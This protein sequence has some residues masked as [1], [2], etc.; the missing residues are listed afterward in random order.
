MPRRWKAPCMEGHGRRCTTSAALS[1]TPAA[2]TLSFKAASSHGRQK[3]MAAAAV[4]SAR[5]TR[6]WS[7]ATCTTSAASCGLRLATPILTP[8]VSAQPVRTSGSPRCPTLRAA[9]GH[10]HDHQEATVPLVARTCERLT[11]CSRLALRVSASLP[12][13][14]ASGARAN[15]VTP[16]AAGRHMEVG[17]QAELAGG[18]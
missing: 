9:G 3:A 4:K 1:C 13:R 7:T 10:A 18:V 5:R 12:A 14:R 8:T 17:L 6:A 2:S 11:F 15:A 16:P